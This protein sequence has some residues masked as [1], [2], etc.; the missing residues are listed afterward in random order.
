MTNTQ[1]VALEKEI[2]KKV[3]DRILVGDTI[4]QL[5]LPIPAIERLLE[6]YST[7][8]ASQERKEREA[9]AFKPE[10]VQRQLQQTGLEVIA[11]ASLYLLLDVNVDKGRHHCHCDYHIIS[12]PFEE[13]IDPKARVE[14]KLGSTLT[15]NGIYVEMTGKDGIGISEGN[16]VCKLKTRFRLPL[17]LP[18]FSEEGLLK[19]RW[20]RIVTTSDISSLRDTSRSLAEANVVLGSINNIASKYG[21]C[22]SRICHQVNGGYSVAVNFEKDLADKKS[23]DDFGKAIEDLSSLPS[24]K[25]DLRSSRKNMSRLGTIKRIQS[26]KPLFERYHRAMQE[27]LK[28]EAPFF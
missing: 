25:S 2:R 20:K 10:Y 3:G 7:Y 11:E 1:I 16:D 13:A 6:L 28:A 22:L 27:Y 26:Y 21:A 8:Q 23:I 4:L 5:R 24:F 14:S 12:D 9:K 17:S 19:G 18:M 15:V